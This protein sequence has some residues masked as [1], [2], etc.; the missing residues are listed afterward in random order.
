VL[1]GSGRNVLPLDFN[2]ITVLMEMVT[3]ILLR[4]VK[5]MV[6]QTVIVPVRPQCHN[7]ESVSYKSLDLLREKKH[8]CRL[9]AWLL[10]AEEIGNRK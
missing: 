8:L 5:Q 4:M 10:L 3:V 9:E 1:L 2:L 7:G 6:C